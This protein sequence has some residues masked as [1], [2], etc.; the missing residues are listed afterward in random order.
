MILGWCRGWGPY[1]ESL[2]VCLD[3]WPLVYRIRIGAPE[4][5]VLPLTLLFSPLSHPL[6][7]PDWSL[8]DGV[9]HHRSGGV[10]SVLQLTLGI[11]PQGNHVRHA[12]PPP[13]SPLSPTSSLSFLPSHPSPS[14]L[15][16]PSWSLRK[17]FHLSGLVVYL[18]G[19][20]LDPNFTALAASLVAFLFMV[21]EVSISIDCG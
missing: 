20:A 18:T 13:S 2:C 8:A 16:S 19:T 4:L 14:S 15:P 6:V 21:A 17:C 7:A 3:N 12:P 10:C 11:S 9:C 1:R 5:L